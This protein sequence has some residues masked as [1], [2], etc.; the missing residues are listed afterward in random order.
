MDQPRSEVT[1]RSEEHNLE[2]ENAKLG[3]S[4]TA[5]RLAAHCILSVT[6]LVLRNRALHIKSGYRFGDTNN[7]LRNTQRVV[8]TMLVKNFQLPILPALQGYLMDLQW[9]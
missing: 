1:W 7:A 8:L 3:L 5:D 2:L 4:T 9:D 6:G